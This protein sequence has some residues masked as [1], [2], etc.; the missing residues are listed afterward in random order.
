MNEE[1]GIHALNKEIIGHRRNDSTD[2]PPSIV[3]TTIRTPLLT[4]SA[5]RGAQN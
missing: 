3:L 4:C 1:E 5:H 2:L